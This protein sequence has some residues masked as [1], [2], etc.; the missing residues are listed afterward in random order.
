VKAKLLTATALAM[1]LQA[2]RASP[3]IFV[4]T[5]DEP[6]N[7][8]VLE[9]NGHSVKMAERGGRF[10]GDSYV[11]DGSGKIVVELKSG[12]SVVCQIAYIT[13]GEFEPHRFSIQKGMCSGS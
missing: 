6:A 12:K 7:A 13:N 5:T 10:A 9:V 3:H 4:V 1:A 11:A 8:A 2:C